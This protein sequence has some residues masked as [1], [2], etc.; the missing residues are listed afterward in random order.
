MVWFDLSKQK[1]QNVNI[2]TPVDQP[3]ESSILNLPRKKKKKIKR[4]SQIIVFVT[5]LCSQKKN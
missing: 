4:N 5:F 2:K 3:S 1:N